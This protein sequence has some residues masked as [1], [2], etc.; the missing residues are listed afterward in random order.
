MVRRQHV[1]VYVERDDG[2][3]VFDHRDHPDGASRSRPAASIP[4][5]A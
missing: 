4:T 2:L 3:L 1:V 5:K